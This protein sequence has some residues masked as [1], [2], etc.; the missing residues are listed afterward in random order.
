MF[1]FGLPGSGQMLTYAF[2]EAL[3]QAM[4]SVSLNT[5][6][7]NASLTDIIDFMKL[8]DKMKSKFYDQN[9]YDPDVE[10]F[11]GLISDSAIDVNSSIGLSKLNRL[12]EREL[13]GKKNQIPGSA[14]IVDVKVNLLVDNVIKSLERSDIRSFHQVIF[15]GRGFRFKPFMDEIKDRLKDKVTGSHKFIYREDISKTVCL[16]GAFQDRKLHINLNSELIGSP[17]VISENSDEEPPKTGI[18]S[19]IAKFFG[20]TDEGNKYID[21]SF[22]REGIKV[23]G[24]TV[25]EICIGARKYSPEAGI[26]KLV[27]P[28]LFYVGNSFLL[29]WKDGTQSLDESPLDFDENIEVMVNNTLFPFDNGRLN[30]SSVTSSNSNVD[31]G[32]KQKSEPKYREEKDPVITV[33][34]EEE[35]IS[36]ED[37]SSIDRTKKP[38]ND[39]VGDF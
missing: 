19:R 9:E 2:I 14:A 37:K 29:R 4:G 34:K 17:V 10:D 26:R 27:K 23:S 7:D 21:E 18:R 38:D 5:A 3:D 6:I 35:T 13:I 20:S 15:A 24:Q 11:E 36:R 25:H 39:R 31:R 28:S 1:R 30:K 33:K 16:E 32:T 8:M 22:Y 12:I